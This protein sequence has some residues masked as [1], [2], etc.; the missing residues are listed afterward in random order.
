[1]K[2]KQ[3]E[4]ACGSIAGPSLREIHFL[5]AMLITSLAAMGAL[6]NSV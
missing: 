4:E 6:V 3:S 2:P 5:N 1:L